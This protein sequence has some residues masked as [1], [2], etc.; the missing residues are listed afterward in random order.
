MEELKINVILAIK[1]ITLM[2]K[3]QIVL[4]VQVIVKDVQAKQFV[5]NAILDMILSNNFQKLT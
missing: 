2:N 3:Q 4:P 5:G 1:T